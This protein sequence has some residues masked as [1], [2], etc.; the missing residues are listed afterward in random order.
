MKMKLMKML[1]QQLS[2]PMIGVAPVSADSSR[3]RF[4]MTLVHSDFLGIAV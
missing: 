3:D 2:E 4:Q 1:I